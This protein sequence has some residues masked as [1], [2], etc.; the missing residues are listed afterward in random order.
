[1]EGDAGR[2]ADPL[3]EAF[4]RD[5]AV[6]VPGAVGAAWLEPLRAAI[7]RDIATPGPFANGYKS[8]DGKGRFHGNAR[9]WEHDATFADYC[10]NSPLPAL[11][12]RFLRTDHVNLLYD[13]LF[14]KEPGTPNPTPWHNDQPYWPIKGWQVMSFWL[15]LDPVTLESGAVEYI[16]GSHKW[17]RWFQ[18]RTFAGPNL[19]ERN[20]DYEDIPDFEAARRQYDIKVW[21]MMPGD[22]IAF[23]AL[24]VHGSG[25]NRRAD[26]RRRGY[27]VRYTGPD[28]TYDPRPGTAQMLWTDQLSPGQRLDSA[29]YPVVVPRAASA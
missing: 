23:H 13:Q 16:A 28:V 15:A 4:E 2:T 5:G 19:Y 6:L 7:D 1:M 8:D 17:D 22:V 21:D 3:V 12:A 25:G 18:P 29:R 14:V 26:L 9:L 27:T 20:P 24:T 10:L 11:A